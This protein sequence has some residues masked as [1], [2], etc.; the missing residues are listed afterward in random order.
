MR[1][2][3]VVMVDCDVRRQP[4]AGGPSAGVDNWARRRCCCL[5]QTWP[6]CWLQ[7]HPCGLGSDHRLPA[8]ML[9]ILL[10]GICKPSSW[11]LT[12]REHCEARNRWVEAAA[13]GS[14]RFLHSNEPL[15]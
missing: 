11:A 14:R 10:A 6:A 15:Q 13:V 12:T 2:V 5:R 1:W 7:R 4:L 8:D 9:L 3:G